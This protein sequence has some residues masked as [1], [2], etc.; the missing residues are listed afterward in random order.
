MPPK[1]GDKTRFPTQGRFCAFAPGDMPVD[2]FVGDVEATARQPIQGAAGNVPRKRPAL[3]VV[4]LEMV[5]AGWWTW[6]F[7][8]PSWG[9]SL[10]FMFRSAD[11]LHYP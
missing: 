8:P 3:G 1:T 4:I 11:P 9:L 6:Q 5:W 2:R 7:A 10:C